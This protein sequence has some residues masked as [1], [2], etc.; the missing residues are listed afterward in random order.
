MFFPNDCYAKPASLRI[1][2]VPELECCLVFTPARPRLY[3]LNATAWLVLELCDGR[4]GSSLQEAYR[5]SLELQE[6][7]ADPNDE[8]QRIVEDFERKGIVVRSPFGAL[9]PVE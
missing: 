5:E 6:D 8:L 1:R 9:S 7:E 2:P 4:S 3:T